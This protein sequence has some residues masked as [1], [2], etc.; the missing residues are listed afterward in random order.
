MPLVTL[1]RLNDLN[2]DIDEAGYSILTNKSADISVT[3]FLDTV[4][5]YLRLF[6]KKIVSAYLALAP[7]EECS[8]KALANVV[9][10]TLKKYNLD[11]K[12]LVGIGTDNASVMT[13]VNNG[14]CAKL[15]VGQPSLIHIRCLCHSLQ[16]AASKAVKE[17]LPQHLRLYSKWYL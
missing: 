9:K 4:I 6:Q 2:N 11:I 7:I 3:K 15:K 5:I 13:G 17:T 8:A 10:S 12:K 1:N 16:L 14:L